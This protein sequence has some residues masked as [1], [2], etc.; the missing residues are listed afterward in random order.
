MSCGADLTDI[1]WGDG[2]QSTSSKTSHYTGNKDEVRGLGS[3]LESTTDESE[4]CRAE[5]AVDTSNTVGKPSTCEC[6][7][8]RPEIIDGDNSSLMS[9]VG[10]SSFRIADAYFHDVI[11]TG[12]DA[13]HNT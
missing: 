13:A 7:N 3:R 11:G 2:S 6:S 8:D 4:D 12:I 10:D 1:D 5:E 9:G